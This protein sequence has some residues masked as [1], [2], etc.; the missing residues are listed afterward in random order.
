[1]LGALR[2]TSMTIVRVILR[3]LGIVVLLSAAVTAL[4]HVAEPIP[5][6]HCLAIVRNKAGQLVRDCPDTRCV[7]HIGIAISMAVVGLGLL[8]GSMLGRRRP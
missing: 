2:P 8:A 1:M 4:V 5:G 3:G 7:R 6:A